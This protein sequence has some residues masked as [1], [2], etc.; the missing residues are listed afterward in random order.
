MLELAQKGITMR[1]IINRLSAYPEILREVD[2]GA[3][4]EKLDCLIEE[5]KSVE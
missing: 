2:R 3:E 1:Q 4:A 5:I